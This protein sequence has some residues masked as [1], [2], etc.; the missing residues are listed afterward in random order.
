MIK[1]YLLIYFL[2]TSCFWV[3]DAVATVFAGG[4]GPPQVQ[5]K[6]VGFLESLGIVA[7]TSRL[8]HERKS[9]LRVSFTS[10]ETEKYADTFV[11]L[12]LL[13]AESQ[14][15]LVV[16]A[17]FVNGDHTVSYVVPRGY[18]VIVSIAK[19]LSEDTEYYKVS[20]INDK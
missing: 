12:L 15:L 9:D 18:S 13:D 4:D 10:S 8:G 19:P 5:E 7:S 6:D 11:E 2:M 3:G 14:V 16:E 1:N 20:F 17:P